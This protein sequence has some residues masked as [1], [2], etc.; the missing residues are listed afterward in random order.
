MKRVT[1]SQ[2]HKGA[3]ED[4]SLPSLSAAEAPVLTTSLSTASDTSTSASKAEKR[5]KSEEN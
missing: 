2:Y 1:K 3:T 4:T 5:N